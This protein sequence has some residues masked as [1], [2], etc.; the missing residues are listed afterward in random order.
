MFTLHFFTIHIDFLFLFYLASVPK[1]N[2]G[3]SRN[4]S[5]AEA[6]SHEELDVEDAVKSSPLR[7]VK[8]EQYQ[9][10]FICFFLF[11]SVLKYLSIE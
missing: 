3:C 5:F 6:S 1:L 11:A 7:Y 8:S 4:L 2:S 10:H 9:S